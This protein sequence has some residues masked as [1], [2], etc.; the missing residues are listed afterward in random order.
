MRAHWDLPEYPTYFGTNKM[1]YRCNLVNIGKFLVKFPEMHLPQLVTVSVL[2]GSTYDMVKLKG[3]KR[4]VKAPSHFM[5]NLHG[6]GYLYT[7]QLEILRRVKMRH[8]PH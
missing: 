8:S 5:F 2:P 3:T 1:G 4:L 6:H 7:W